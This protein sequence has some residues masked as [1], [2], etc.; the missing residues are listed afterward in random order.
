MDHI[1]QKQGHRR[2]PIFVTKL[3]I[4]IK[5]N[6]RWQFHQLVDLL[7]SVQEICQSGTLLKSDLVEQAKLKWKDDG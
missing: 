7:P 4:F 6:T 3:W 5:K 1:E 2:T